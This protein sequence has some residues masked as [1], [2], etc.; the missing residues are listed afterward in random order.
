[1]NGIQLSSWQ[2][3]KAGIVSTTK[4]MLKWLVTT[5]TG[6][7]IIGA[8][9]IT[10]MVVALTSMQK[11][12]E[13]A[14]EATVEKIQTSPYKK[15]GYIYVPKI[16]HLLY[17]VHPYKNIAYFRPL[18]INSTLCNLRYNRRFWNECAAGEYFIVCE[19]LS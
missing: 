12:S 8:T 14:H 16:N 13:K 9:A 11:A 10:G 17:R 1:M 18:K 3:L 19:T 15:R 2:A 6:W 4:A 7:A 5:P